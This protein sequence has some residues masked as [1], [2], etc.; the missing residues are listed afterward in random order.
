[1]HPTWL[2]KNCFTY[3]SDVKARITRIPYFHDA[4]TNGDIV[5]HEGRYGSMLR[6]RWPSQAADRRQSMQGLRRKLTIDDLPTCK[7]RTELDSV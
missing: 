1:M 7:G 6:K 4:D 2:N 5:R 3:P